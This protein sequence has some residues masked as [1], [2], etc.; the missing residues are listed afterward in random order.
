MAD[1]TQMMTLPTRLDRY[2]LPFVA[3]PPSAVEINDPSQPRAAVPH[4]VPHGVALQN[5]RAILD[6]YGKPYVRPETAEV[7][8][9]TLGGWRYYAANTVADLLTPA[10]LMSLLREAE[11]GNILHQM[12]LFEAMEERDARLSGL[13]TQRKAGVTSCGFALEPGDDSAQALRAR[14]FCAALLPAGDGKRLGRIQSWSDRLRDLLDAVSKGFSCLEILWET[15]ER[16][17]APVDLKFRPQRWWTLDLVDRQKLLLR[18]VS[19][20]LGLPVNPFNFVMHRHNAHSG[21]LQ[22]GGISLACARPFLVRN[23][24][25][26]DWL[27][28]ADLCGIPV[29]LGELPAGATQEDA[30]L[31]WR[32]LTSLGSA[33]AGM[34]PSGGKIT[35]ADNARQA[36]D[37]ELFDKLR[38]RAGGEMDL[39]ILGQMFTS[40]SGAGGGRGLGFSGQ[41]H[42]NV[43]FDL[44]DSDARA[45]DETLNRQFFGPVTLLNFGPETPAPI[46]RTLAEEP[47][48]LQRLATSVSTLVSVGLRVPANWARKKFGIPEPEDGEEMLAPSSGSYGKNGN[49]GKGEAEHG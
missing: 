11:Q 37:G 28:L 41:A 24:A 48:D 30:D 10:R 5:P 3:Q 20:P 12:E 49:D 13:F 1:M 34:V 14:D 35:F 19:A 39:A 46:Y 26:R 29:R 9:A 32:A 44:V 7:A 15:S 38:E 45:L 25:L 42:E 4:G 8:P 2:G 36:N 21:S 17:W 47:V 18:D 6:Q 23:Y 16:Q 22:R 33:A 27:Q 31:M 40:G 43:R